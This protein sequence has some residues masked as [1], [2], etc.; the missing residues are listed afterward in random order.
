MTPEPSTAPLQIL[1]EVFGYTAFRGAQESI[2]DH[3]AADG[4]ALVLM[5]TGGGGG[6]PRGASCAWLPGAGAPPAPAPAAAWRWSSA[7]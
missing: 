7:R 1:Q 6:A 2:V 5:P 4:D 3:V